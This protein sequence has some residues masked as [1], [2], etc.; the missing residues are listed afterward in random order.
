[1]I[2]II[3]YILILNALWFAPLNRVEIA[4]L[5]PIQAVWMNKEDGQILLKTDTGSRGTGQTVADALANL[6]ET[7]PSIVYLDTAEYLLV[8]EN[9]EEEI[10]ALAPYVKKSVRLCQWD[11]EGDVEWAVKYANAHKIGTK[12]CHWK[13]ADKLPNLTLQNPS[14]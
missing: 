7:S 5:E 4:N 3:L 9:A 6:K 1:M 8:S 13:T 14:K 2:R 10:A 12:I 11:G